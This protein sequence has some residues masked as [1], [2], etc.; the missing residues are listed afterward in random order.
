[1]TKPVFFIDDDEYERRSSTD[2]LNEIFKGTSIHVEALAP[3]PTLADYSGLVAKRTASALIVDE[4]LNTAGG[5]AYTGAEL[6]AHLRA[7]GGNLPIVILTNFPDDDFNKQGWAV[8]SI[9]AKKCVLNDPASP[10]AQAFKARLSR[11][12]EIAGA[13][14]A[15]REQ[16]FHDLLVKSLKESLTPEEEKELGLLETERILP[17]QAEELPDAKSLQKTIEELKAKLNPGQLKL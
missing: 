3:L 11:Q 12:I 13:V 10:V 5:V 17:V 9:I 15:E 14:L 8:E 6:A 1:M 4:R 16:R 2:V 7:I